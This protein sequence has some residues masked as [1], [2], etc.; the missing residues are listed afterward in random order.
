[1]GKTPMSV[2]K[3]KGQKKLQAEVNL[4]VAL[5]YKWEFPGNKQCKV[6]LGSG[7][8]EICS[9]NIQYASTK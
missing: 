8:E 7:N 6:I 4:T 1:M 2:T 3:S 5:K 9:W